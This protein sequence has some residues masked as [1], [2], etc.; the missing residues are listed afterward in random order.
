MTQKNIFCLF[1]RPL[2]TQKNGI[3]LFEISSF[4]PHGFGASYRGFPAFLA[5]S[6]ASYRDI[7][8][9][10]LC[11]LVSEDVIIRFNKHLRSAHTR[12]ATSPCD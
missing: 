9:F 3:C 2:K 7:D 11:K 6:Y 12:D 1:A 10:L 4:A 8:V 5:P